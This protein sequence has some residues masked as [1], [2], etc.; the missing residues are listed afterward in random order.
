MDF[1]YGDCTRLGIGYCRTKSNPIVDGRE[2]LTLCGIQELPNN[3]CIIWGTEMEEWHNNLMPEDAV[4]LPRA[5][6]HLFGVALVPTGPDSFDVEY[7]LQLSV[8]GRIPGFLT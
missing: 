1:G 5:K 4:R 2:Q 3:G 6:S 8:G 7:I